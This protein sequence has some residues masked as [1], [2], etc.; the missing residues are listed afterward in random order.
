MSKYFKIVGLVIMIL[1]VTSY[2]FLNYDKQY[3]KEEIINNFFESNT[4]YVHGNIEASYNDKYEKD[5]LLNKI[6]KEQIDGAKIFGKITYNNGKYNSIFNVYS[7]YK[8]NKIDRIFEIN[9]SF[10]NNVIEKIIY[11]EE[12]NKYI[13]DINDYNTYNLKSNI[14]V[15]MY[16]NENKIIK[17]I[18]EI[19]GKYERKLNM[20]VNYIVKIEIEP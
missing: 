18:I 8:K 3:T 7:K 6:V 10:K 17:T 11:D 13:L 20:D 4:L 5:F 1:S 16:K 15:E 9:E 19:K 2:I 12:N 14:H